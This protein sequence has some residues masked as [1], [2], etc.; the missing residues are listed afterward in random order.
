MS[1]SH[2]DEGLS[3][4]TSSS[5]RGGVSASQGVEGTMSFSEVTLALGVNGGQVSN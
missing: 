2:C 1:E 3:P 5:V 4:T